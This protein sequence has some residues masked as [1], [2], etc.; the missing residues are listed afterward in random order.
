MR[1][2][3]KASRRSNGTALFLPLPLAGEVAA[4]ARA[5]RV[6]E[7]SRRTLAPSMPRPPPPHPPPQAG[8]G[9]QP[10]NMLAAL[11]P[12]YVADRA[13]PLHRYPHRGT[14]AAHRAVAE[15]DVAAMRARD[16]AGDRKAE[17]R[18]AFILVAGIIQPQERLEHFLAHVRRNA[19][20]VV[21][22]R[23]RQVA[24]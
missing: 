22:D 5:R 12:R 18:P 14:Q 21:V 24:M 17:A 15:R 4:L 7:I 8:E 20:S 16:V 6:G 10:R 3:S 13:P 9:A 23:D 1:K 11:Y 2:C 19:R